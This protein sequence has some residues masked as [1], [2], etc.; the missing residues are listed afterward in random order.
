LVLVELL[1][2]SAVELLEL[3]RVVMNIVLLKVNFPSLYLFLNFVHFCQIGLQMFRLLRMR[4]WVRERFKCYCDGIV[5]EITVFLHL[6][7]I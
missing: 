4:Q 7:L 5:F 6:Y 1:D 3:P 2:D